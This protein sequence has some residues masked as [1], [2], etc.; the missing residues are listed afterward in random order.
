MNSLLDRISKLF[1]L[2]LKE[3]GAGAR[4]FVSHA[5]TVPHSAFGHPLPS[6]E[7]VFGC[8]LRGF[9][10]LLL[11]GMCSC[12]KESGPTENASAGAKK[13][14]VAYIP[15][16]T[17]NPYFDQIIKGF[18]DA[19]EKYDFEFTTTAPAKATATSQIPYIKSQ[20]QQRVDVIAISPN[21]EDALDLVF[22]QA[23][24]RGIKVFIVNSD[25]ANPDQRDLA[26]LPIDFSKV[27]EQQL[28]MLGGMVDY[29]GDIAIL[30][31][32]TDAPDQNEWIKGMRAQLKDNAKFANMK[33]VDVVYGDDDDQKSLTE[34]TALITRYPNLRG[35]I[36]PTSVGLPATAQAIK[37]AGVYPGGP[38][39]KGPGIVATGLATPNLMRT[40]VKEGIV[41]QFA[42]WQPYDE[43]LIGGYLAVQIVREGL[44]PKAS[45]EVEIPELGM[46]RLNENRTMVAGEPLEFTAENVDEFQF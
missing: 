19:A 12:G 29:Q 8:T 4:G 1:P 9:L 27:G 37:L 44:E 42:L 35:I 17:G 3:E 24:D 34:C 13:I 28:D 43:G 21:S 18:E 38:N 39:A 7:R 6:G 20:I 23:R 45:S 26:I 25:I 41:E 32:T 22:Q 40:Y 36:A 2:P 31:A 5:K 11:V 46:R 15:K 16:N 14:K 33:L 10:I 30:S